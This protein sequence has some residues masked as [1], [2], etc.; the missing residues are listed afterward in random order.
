MNCMKKPE[1]FEKIRKEIDTEIVQPFTGE[2]NTGIL[3]MLDFEN[4]YNL[5]YYS[6]CFYESLRIQAPV[7]NSTTLQ[8]T[9]TSKCNWL[10]ISENTAITIDM[11]CLHHN[12]KEWIEPE[13]FIPDRF[14]PTSVYFFTPSGS[15][16]N[17]YSFAP[18]LGGQ[19]ICLGKTFAET[20]S[21]FVGP[22]LAHKY[23]FEF[24]DKSIPLD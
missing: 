12:A 22:T 3:D 1:Y 9:K 16:R 20:V 6:M 7:L 17:P 13:K 21:K 5:K 14:D 11:R 24:E 2:K 10:T 8:L 4:V 19:R 15:K 18:F 23:S